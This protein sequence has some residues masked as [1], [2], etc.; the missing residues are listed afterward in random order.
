MAV[1]VR[2][3]LT[4]LFAA[5]H[6]VANI[7]NSAAYAAGAAAPVAKPKPA[8]SNSSRKGIYSAEKHA[9]GD[10]IGVLSKFKMTPPQRLA[11]RNYIGQG[12]GDVHILSSGHEGGVETLAIKHAKTGAFL[13]R[14]GISAGPDGAILV[15]KSTA[16]DLDYKKS[17]SVPLKTKIDPKLAQ[18]TLGG[19]K[20]LELM[21]QDVK[22]P[23]LTAKLPALKPV[24]GLDFA[25]AREC[26]ARF[27]ADGS[28]YEYCLVSKPAAPVVAAGKAAAKPAPQAARTSN[29]K[30]NAGSTAAAVAAGVVAGAALEGFVNYFSRPSIDKEGRL[31]HSTMGT[32]YRVNTT[33][34]EMQS[35]YAHSEVDV[36]PR[37]SPAPRVNVTQQTNVA[38]SQTTINEQEIDVTQVEPE[39]GQPGGEVDF[40]PDD[41]V[42]MVPE[43]GIP[44]GG[45]EGAAA[46]SA[47][48]TAQGADQGT[49]TAAD[50]GQG[51][52]DEET[53]P[54]SR[55]SE[56][57]DENGD[58]CGGYGIPGL[59]GI[60]TGGPSCEEPNA[61]QR[62]ME[63]R[64][65]D[66]AL[67]AGTPEA[68][69][70][71]LQ[72]HPES[73]HAEEAL[74]LLDLGASG[75]T[76]QEMDNPDAPE[77]S[78]PGEITSAT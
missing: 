60:Y 45:D 35:R 54:E 12:G 15:S 6:V 30:S 10:V 71:F 47:E 13:G 24:H 72:E 31:S 32:R 25:S 39:G 48:G 38:Q 5:A 63:D 29:G 65:Y 78:T 58:E 8:P 34:P 18:K 43:V 37:T 41:N 52:D 33:L 42:P 62:D 9:S 27:N 36:T 67:S 50:E 49:D 75:E 11:V 55:G 46:I 22:K 4:F 7:L 21:Q 28:G 74:N 14:I 20:Q 69:E 59:P 70:T 40:T 73:D 17:V 61:L 44:E 26:T 66:K 1:R 19:S 16:A 56:D 64:D 76:T 2:K 51:P 77:N 53:G 23:I 68:L 57:E 3:F